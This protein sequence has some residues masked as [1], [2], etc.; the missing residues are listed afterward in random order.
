MERVLTFNDALSSSNK[1]RHL[2]L[3]NGFSI[4]LFP[5]I[6]S[7]GS[8]LEKADFSDVQ[9]GNK[10]F[11]ALDTSDF[12]SVIRRLYDSAKIVDLYPNGSAIKK[13]MEIDANKIKHILVNTI[14][15]RHPKKPDEIKTEQYVSCRQFLKNFEHIY[16]LNY[17]LLLYWT[18]MQDIDDFSKKDD[19]FRNSAHKSGYVEWQSYKKS[20][21]HYL[22][23]ALHLFDTG[24]DIL[25]YTWNRTGIPLIDQIRT[26]LDNEKY[27]LIVSEGDSPGKQRK[28]IHNA[29]LH[30]CLRSLESI[31]GCVFIYGHS[32]DDNDK[33][34]F[35]SIIKNKNIDLLM[36]S[37][38][39]DLNKDSNKKIQENAQRLV[40]ER[41]E[42]FDQKPLSIKFYQAETANI[43]NNIVSCLP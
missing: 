2:L 43:W 26:A 39:G 30:K 7:Y 33:H 35:R 21:I 4:A 27:P 20:T 23:G 32:L 3:G 24:T 12:E 16:T 34:I 11:Q 36:I 13:Q 10:L 38:Y 1:K 9:R 41:E 31:S 22:H 6:F 17:D 18:L 8:L 25:K 15:T 19:G 28:I 37:L 29:Y 5:K 14:A 40:M 42:L